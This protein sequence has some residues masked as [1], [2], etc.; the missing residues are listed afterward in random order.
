MACNITLSDMPLECRDG[1]GGIVEVYALANREAMTVV[2][3]TGSTGTVSAI[4]LTSGNS[5]V[6]YA[7]RKNTGSLTNTYNISEENGTTFIRSELT[8]VFHKLETSK[9]LEISA[10]AIGNMAMIVKDGNGK[11][12]LLGKDEAVTMASG[13]SQTGTAKGDMNGYNVVLACEGKEEPWEVTAEAMAA[14]LA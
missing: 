6:T 4:T 10:L 7:L 12:W 2:P 9:R 1:I 13:T 14:L 5:F 11:F 3:S 8:L